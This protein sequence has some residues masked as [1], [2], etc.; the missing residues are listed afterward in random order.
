MNLDVKLMFPSPVP[1][2]IILNLT[3]EPETSV[4]VNWRTDTTV[5]QGVIEVARSTDGTQFT[6]QLRQ[7]NATTQYLRTRH[8]QEPAV[9]ANYHSAVINGLTPGSVYVYR[10]GFGKG[11]SEWFQ[12]KMPE[13]TKGRALSFLYFGD[14]QN[15]VKSHWSRVIREAYKKMPEVS[16][17]LHAGDLINRHDHDIEWGEWFQAGSF[18]HASVPSVMTPGNHEYRNVKLSP[19]WRPQYNLPQNGPKGLEETCYQV[20]YHDLKV[21]SLDA[22]QI[23]ESP[24]YAQKQAQWLDSILTNDP[25]RW[26]VL[27]IHYPF[28]ST[29][30]NRENVELRNRFKPI[31]DKHKVDIVLQG[32]DHAYGRGMVS[33]TPSGQNR[34][35]QLSGTMYVV[36]VAGPKM[37]DL[38]DDPWMFRKAGNSQM[39]QIITI[40]DNQLLYNAYTATGE[41]YDS[42]ILEK[43]QGKANTLVDKTPNTPE[44]R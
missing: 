8:E 18:I 43:K 22:E 34:R 9:S 11:W 14:A 38:S 44:K 4:A 28:Y 26:T 15:D 10:V 39:F 5:Q 13:S 32:H 27:T 3:A 31:L 16:F 6:K 23:D 42:F 25:R 29:K 41:L 36:S 1:D 19:H 7:I 12:F 40:Q 24:Y 30:P 2:R 35:A 21:I 37:Y 17:M 20:N 33:N